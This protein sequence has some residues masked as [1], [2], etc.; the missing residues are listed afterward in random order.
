MLVYFRLNPLYY[1]VR[2]YRDS[3]LY[4]VPFWKNPVDTIYFWGIALI[5]FVIGVLVFK[6][7]RP[8]FAEMV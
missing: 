1:I 4:N 3:L 6:R 5:F 8:Y 7:L 2:G